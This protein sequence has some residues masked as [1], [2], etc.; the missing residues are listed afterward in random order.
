[1]EEENTNTSEPVDTTE[2]VENPVEETAAEGEA[3]ATPTETVETDVDS[4]A[5]LVPENPQMY[6]TSFATDDY[7][8][9]LVH[10]FTLGDVLIATLLCVLIIITLLSRLLGGGR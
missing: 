9:T 10:D 6:S 5:E 4:W 1:M 7:V 3:A 2:T 8:I